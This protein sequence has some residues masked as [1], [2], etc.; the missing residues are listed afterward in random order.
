MTSV[1]LTFDKTVPVPAAPATFESLCQLIETTFPYAEVQKVTYVDD[2]GDPVSVR[3][4]KDLQEAY[5]LCGLW[6]RT[7][8]ELKLEGKVLTQSFMTESVLQPAEEEKAVVEDIK[9]LAVEEV[10]M[11]EPPKEP[12]LPSTSV[13]VSVEDA[14]RLVQCAKCDGRGVSGKRLITCKW[15]SGSGLMD[16]NRNPKVKQLV[17]LVRKEVAAAIERTE[18]LRVAKELE[19]T[20]GE[21]I[22]VRCDGCG[23]NPIIGCRYK[24][25]ICQSFDYCPECEDT[26]KHDH[27]FIKIRRPEQNPTAILAVVN[28]DLQ[29]NPIPIKPQAKP[30]RLHCK[31]VSDVEGRDGQNVV[32]GSTIRKIWR[33]S[34]PGKEWPVGCSFVC[35]QGGFQGAPVSLPPLSTNA[36]HNISVTCT[37]PTTIGRYQSFWQAKDPQGK[38]FGDRLWIDITV[39]EEASPDEQIQVYMA[40]NSEITRE[41]M[42]LYGNDTRLALQQ[43]KELLS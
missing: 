30:E 10:K 18:I 26:R 24:C 36:E 16:I 11:P 33:V 17:E 35:V 3:T 12:E 6:S 34:N 21:H 2:D 43:L 27:P 22:G 41:V 9:K 38:F 29:G 23:Q 39:T 8:L 5:R 1:T 42:A 25:S 7:A 19:R 32:A 4:T 15:C 13:R 28:E 31:F 20:Q 40:L 37:V 14:E